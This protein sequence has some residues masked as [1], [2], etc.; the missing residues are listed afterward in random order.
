MQQR[1]RPKR[2]ENLAVSA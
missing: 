2:T 1:K